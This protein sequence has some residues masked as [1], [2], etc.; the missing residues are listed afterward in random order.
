MKLTRFIFFGLILF[1]FS[2]KTVSLS[3]LQPKYRLSQKLPYLQPEFDAKSFYMLLGDDRRSVKII[4]DGKEDS[5]H[6]AV[7]ERDAASYKVAM[8]K[9]LFEKAVKQNFCEYSPQSHGQIKCRLI[10]YLPTSPYPF[11]SAL[12][13]FSFYSLNLLG[14]PV[15]ASKAEVEIEVLIYNQDNRLVADYHAYGKHV[16]PV[17][18]YYGANFFNVKDI[19]FLK[20]FRNALDTV[21]LRLEADYQKI[22][23]QL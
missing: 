9:A 14:M 18:F 3:S 4:L 13:V 22:I 21:G 6:T 8:A 7:W 23:K 20:A 15:T 10:S 12:S 16:E 5:L 17:G 1:L 11:L 2:C 19:A